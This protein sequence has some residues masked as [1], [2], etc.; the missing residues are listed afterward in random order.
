MRFLPFAATL[1]AVAGCTSIQ[2]SNIKTAGMS[3]SMLVSAD[4]TGAA[5][6]SAQLNVDNNG[7]DFVDLSSGDTLVASAAGQMQTMSRVSALGEITYQASFGGADTAGTQF[8]IALNR[9]SDV[10]APSS[11]CAM[12]SPFNVTT[13]T[14]SDVFSRS[15]SDIVVQYDHAGTQDSMTWTA[16]GNCLN[17]QSSGSVSGDAGTFTIARGT[18]SA[19]GGQT[20]AT[21]QVQITLTRARVGQLDS[22]FAA[23]GSIRAQQ[24]R[25]VS[26]NSAP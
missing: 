19:A 2:S 12:P 1:I 5:K 4:G 7:T 11:T 9:T 15:T 8:T 26:F 10:S 25:S 18:L 23:G 14:S 3:A 22:H 24:V 21:C 17:G 16:S 13:P 20:N 6:V